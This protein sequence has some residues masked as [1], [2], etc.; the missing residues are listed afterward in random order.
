MQN[1]HVQQSEY[2]GWETSEEKKLHRIDNNH[3]KA[4]SFTDQEAQKNYSSS[5]HQG[6]EDNRK[7]GTK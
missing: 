6:L 4:G 7:T 1:A 3:H 2:G 5:G